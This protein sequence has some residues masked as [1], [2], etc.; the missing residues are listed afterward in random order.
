MEDERNAGLEEGMLKGKAEVL[1]LSVESVM[2]K[3]KVDLGAACE[4]VGTTV[5][6]YFKAKEKLR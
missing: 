1:V 5:D 2:L 3:F 6:A 4:G